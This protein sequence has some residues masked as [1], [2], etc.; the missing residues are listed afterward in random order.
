M[1]TQQENLMEE[2]VN[3]GFAV[4]E[5]F[6]PIFVYEKED[7]EGRETVTVFPNTHTALH[8]H[9]HRSGMMLDSNYYST[10]V[11]ADVKKLLDSCG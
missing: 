1:T 6:G 4:T 3:R 9:W 7:G 10:E 5:L 8:E 2:L 11:T